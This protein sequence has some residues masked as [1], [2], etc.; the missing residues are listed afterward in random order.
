MVVMRVD[1][2]LG[3]GKAWDLML[4]GEEKKGGGGF[5]EARGGGWLDWIG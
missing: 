3:W 2:G 5:M 1:L 4:L